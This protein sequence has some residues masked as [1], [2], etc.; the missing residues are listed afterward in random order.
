MRWRRRWGLRVIEPWPPTRFTPPLSEDFPSL[1]GRYKEAFRIAWDAAMGYRLEEWQES[2]LEAIT[3]VFPDGH[4]RAGELRYRQTLTTVG[5]QQGK[6]EIAAALGLLFMIVFRGAL[7]IGIASSADQA[8]LVYRR[9]MQVIR[10]NRALAKRFDALTDTRGLRDKFGGIWELKAAKSAALQGL[11]ITLG[12]VDEVHLVSRELWYDLVAGTGGRPNAMVAGITTAGDESSKLLLELID[13]GE[14]AIKDP[15]L[16]FGF[17]A[18]EAPEA[19]VPSD[20]GKLLEYL[21]AAN[22]ALAS[23]RLDAENVLADV[24]ATPDADV[25][26][27]RLNRFVTS[28][29]SFIPAAL[30]ASVAR[31]EGEEMPRGPLAFGVDAVRDM[32]H[33]SIVAAVRAEDG[34]I[35]TEL[36]A[37]ITSPRLEQLANVCQALMR[38]SP[39][40]FVVEGYALRS[41]GKELQKRGMPVQILGT[42]EILNASPL[43]YRKIVTRELR[44]DNAPLLALQVPRTVRKNIGESYR[45]S[46]PDSSVEID[47]VMALAMAVYAADTAMERV[48]QIF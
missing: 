37:S 44:H 26:R 23:G 38:H 25:I 8:R 27:Y 43:L 34:T 36:I 20:E 15:S 14:K 12:E 40:A 13:L 18:W 9:A 10:G 46:R 11:D 35:W 5:R 41:L 48:P 39:A 7:V 22:P 16:R 17:F 33:A 19:A 4:D 24:R 3:E 30:W 29:N 32:S 31:A 42:G 21:K 1:F 2:L 45:I 47:A 28:I 6:T